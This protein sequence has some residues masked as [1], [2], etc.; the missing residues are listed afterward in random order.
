MHLRYRYEVL[1]G[2]THCRVFMGPDRQH[3]ASCG[4][5]VMR[6]EEFNLLKARLRGAED[7]LIDFIS[8][9]EG[10]CVHEITSKTNGFCPKCGMMI[11]KT[12]KED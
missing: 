6:N 2:H 9:T 5:L 4:S 11:F 10:A 12:G 8:E 3:L 7:L 1:G